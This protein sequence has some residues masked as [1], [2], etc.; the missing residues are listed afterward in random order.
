MSEWPSQSP[1]LSPIENLWKDLNIGVHRRCLSNPTV[2]E[3]IAN[4]NGQKF[5]SQNV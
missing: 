3:L 5:Q 2:P 4:K 1:N